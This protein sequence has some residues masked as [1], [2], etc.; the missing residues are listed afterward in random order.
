[1]G[2]TRYMFCVLACLFLQDDFLPSGT[3][4]SQSSPTH[5]TGFPVGLLIQG[6]IIT[7]KDFRTKKC[8]YSTKGLEKAAAG[9]KE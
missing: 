7:I 6:F 1:M 3:A 4:E 5:M 9:R 2:T 8:N